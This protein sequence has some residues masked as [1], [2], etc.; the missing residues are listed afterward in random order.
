M[1]LLET[2]AGKPLALAR[3]LEL[4]QDSGWSMPDCSPS[5]GIGMPLL[6][7]GPF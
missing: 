1:H 5:E 6:K 4:L 7:L 2:L 3:G